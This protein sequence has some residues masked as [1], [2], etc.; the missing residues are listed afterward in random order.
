MALH[1]DKPIIVEVETYQEFCEAIQFPVTRIMLDALPADDLE[2]VFSHP[3][4]CKNASTSGIQWCFN[5][6]CTRD[7]FIASNYRLK[8]AR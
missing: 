2:K 4:D 8:T 6:K 1:P 5:Q 7:R 3:T